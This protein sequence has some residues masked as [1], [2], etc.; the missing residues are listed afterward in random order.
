[1]MVM[2]VILLGFFLI[3][4]KVVCADTKNVSMKINGVP[5]N[6]DTPPQLINGK[7]FI[8]ARG[9]LETLGYKIK[10]DRNTKRI[11]AIRKEKSIILKVG[12]KEVTVEEKNI[13]LSEPVMISHAKIFVGADFMQK[14]L[15]MRLTW[16][17]KMALCSVWS[18]EVENISITGSG[19]FITACEDS[20]LHI[21]L[22]AEN[23][24]VNEMLKKAN[25]LLQDNHLSE[26]ISCYDGIL[27]QI[28]SIKNP[29]EYSEVKTNL[30]NA[31]Y[32]LS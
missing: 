22:K 12:S 10:W 13:A 7:L 24:K 30:G 32:R 27:E 25:K 4:P 31:Y 18:K 16:D 17:E 5:V 21:T 3:E 28:S 6:F 19:N 9:L 14:G 2:L 15:S 1:M 11:T 26:A 8:P 29:K 23:P 20:I